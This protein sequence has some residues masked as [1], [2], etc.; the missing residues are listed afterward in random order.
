MRTLT[1]VR[2]RFDEMYQR[3]LQKKKSEYLTCGFRNCKFNH[4]QR[5]REN[6]KVG[7]CI[8]PMVLSKVKNNIFVCNGD[9]VAKSC[10]EFVC[11]NTEESVQREFLSDISDPAVC[12][13]KHPK[14]A[15]LLWYLQ[16]MPAK[17]EPLR[18]TRFRAS[19]VELLRSAIRFLSLK[20]W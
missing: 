3:C 9:D 17:D 15:V 5:V 19:L 4:I 1:E 20:W 13:Q 11:K 7:F 18:K 2:E 12:G 8:N 6:G 10:G 16:D 14:L